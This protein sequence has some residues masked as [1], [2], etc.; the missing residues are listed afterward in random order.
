MSFLYTTDCANIFAGKK[1]DYIYVS[2][3]GK[4][5]TNDQDQNQEPY[6]QILPAHVR[7]KKNA[8][9]VAV[10]TFPPD[11]R[12]P[13]YDGITLVIYHHE[14]TI[15][16]LD[17]FLDEI[18]IYLDAYHYCADQFMLCNFI[19]FLNPN[20]VEQTAEKMFPAQI[21]G[22]FE[23]FCFGKY[24]ECFYQWYGH[25]EHTYHWVYNYSR[26]NVRKNVDFPELHTLFSPIWGDFS[27]DNQS[28]KTF[29]K[30]SV[31]LV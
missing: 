22:R 11:F 4:I 27:D 23:E 7:D 31:K 8:L 3:G 12:P 17:E 28:M 30:N 2:V 29:L 1:Y 26:Y 21:H 20:A 13:I 25:Y 14:F 19:R 10:D 9:V 15:Q 5:N 24:K 16:S 18:L 6:F